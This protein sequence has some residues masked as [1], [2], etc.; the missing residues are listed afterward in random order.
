[1]W[2]GKFGRSIIS[3]VVLGS[4]QFNIWFVY[5][6]E[7]FISYFALWGCPPWLVGFSGCL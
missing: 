4:V 1:M 6:P 2:T 3:I 7:E 5:A